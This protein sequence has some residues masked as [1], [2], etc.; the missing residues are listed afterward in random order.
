MALFNLEYVHECREGPNCE[1]SLELIA[2]IK[3]YR[4]IV[5]YAHFIKGLNRYFDDILLYY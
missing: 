5:Q 2:E 4:G 3:S 1:V